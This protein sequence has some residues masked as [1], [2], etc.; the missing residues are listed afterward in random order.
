MSKIRA[1]L[2]TQVHAMESKTGSYM[3]IINEE[4]ETEIGDVRWPS[5]TER[6]A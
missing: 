1:D 5:R 2:I 4:L 3:R 6:K